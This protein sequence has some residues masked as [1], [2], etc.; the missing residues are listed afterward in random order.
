MHLPKL[1]GRL[2]TVAL[3]TALLAVLVPAMPALGRSLPPRQVQSLDGLWQIKPAAPTPLTHTMAIADWQWKASNLGTHEPPTTLPAN[4][5]S[6]TWHHYTIGTDIFNG[7]VGYAWFQAKLPHRSALIASHFMLQFAGVRTRALVFLNG[8][9]LTD[10]RGGYLWFE[11]PLQNAMR[12]GANTLTL[13]VHNPGQKGATMGAV[14]LGAYTPQNFAANPACMTDAANGFKPVLVPDDF[15]A[16]GKFD[17]HANGSHGYLPVYPVWYRRTFTIPATARGHI[18]QLRFGG[19]MSGAVVYVNGKYVGE[20]ADGYAPFWFDISGDIRYGHRNTLA[21]YVDPRIREGWWYEG[22]G[23]YRHVSLVT[24]QALHITRWGTY[25]ISDVTGP[26]HQRGTMGDTASATLTLQTTVANHLNHAQTFTLKSSVLS[27]DDTAGHAL[28][29]AQT[30]TLPAGATITFVQHVALPEA[31]LWSLHH[32][33]L[34]TLKTQII[35]ADGHVADAK[36]VHFGIRTIRYDADRGFFLNGKSVKLDGTCNHQDFPAVGVGTPDNLWWWRVARLK[37]IGSNAYRCSH[38]PMGTALY[39]ACDHLGMLVMDENRALGDVRLGGKYGRAKSYPGVPY[40]D[41]H[42]L[43]TMILRDRNY[44]CIIMWSLCNEEIKIQGTPFG[45][46]VFKQAMKAVRKLDSTRPITCA[47]SGG[48]PHGF[49][50]VE[51]LLGINY[52]P[53]QYTP[54]HKALP[55]MP[56][57]S[58]ETGS[59]ESDRGIMQSNKAKGLV[60]QYTVHSGWSQVPWDAWGPIGRRPYIAGGF[61]WTG[62]DYRG[63]P[64][65]YQ[66]PDINSHF[67]LLDICG[68]PKPDAYY[69]KAAWTTKPMVYVQPQWDLPGTKIGSPITVRCFSNCQEVELIANGKNMGRK[70]FKPFGYVDWKVPYQPGKLLVRGYNDGRLVA[71]YSDITPGPAAAIKLTNQWPTLTADGQSIAPVAVRILDSKGNVVNHSMRKITFSISGPGTIAGTSNG[72]PAS[73]IA[74]DVSY[75]RA[76]FGRCMVLVRTGHQAGVI[77]VTA[78][79]AGLPATTIRIRT[80]PAPAMA[81]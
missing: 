77:S 33:N 15:V 6:G 64:T 5:N 13:L 45:A 35:A 60:T 30:E 11:V 74:N 57:F 80:E 4:L 63:E 7:K 17:P 38:N 75:S 19:V 25:A 67:G 20:H 34:Y 1:P 81:N 23:I 39:S 40:G 66:W 12:Q 72:N 46:K 69:Y 52:A 24:L 16:Q 79:S 71:S 27:P 31:R 2:I 56:I 62:F 61:I 42:N 14:T 29:A 70:T 48:Y 49:T 58:S 44:P 9:L 22:G 76:F 21:V 26:I 37:G 47:M 65:P 55:H 8:K 32:C 18:V 50:T 54:M 43:Q 73:H 36:S 59:S 10:H 41:F 78:H 53:Q 3:L 51:D 28:T 68:F